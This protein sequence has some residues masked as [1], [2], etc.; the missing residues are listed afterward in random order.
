MWENV[1]ALLFEADCNFDQV[2]HMLVYLRDMADYQVVKSMFDDRF[3]KTPKVFLQAPV[4]RP[5]WLI[6]MECMAVKE[7]HNDAFAPF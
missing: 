7:V 1:E 5:A 4:C 6:E 3:P 2:A